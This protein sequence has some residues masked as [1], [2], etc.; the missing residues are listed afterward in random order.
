M[1]VGLDDAPPVPMQ[2]GSPETGDFSGYEVSLL[3]ELAS[4]LGVS[5]TYRRA[6]W[7]VIVEELSAG[8]L[9]LVCS[10]ATVTEERA[11]QVDFCTPHLQLALSLVTREDSAPTAD[12]QA[13]RVGIRRGTTAEAY[14]TKTAPGRAAAILSESNDELYDA[15]S[16]GEL[17]VVIDD[18]PIAL[19]FATSKAGLK[20]AGSLPGTQGAYAVMLRRGNDKLRGEINSALAQMETDGTLPRLR[21]EWFGADALFVA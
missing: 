15:L 13:G 12:L 9:D 6:F 18:S 21:K 11:E 16:A 20:Y 5:L 19:H 3:D 7:S 17:D 4:R 14:F 8:R 2:M 10:A 1:R